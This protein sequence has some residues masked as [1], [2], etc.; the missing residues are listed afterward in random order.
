MRGYVARLGRSDGSV[1]DV[2]SASQLG[3]VRV[4]VFTSDPK[5]DLIEGH[6]RVPL[7]WTH[8]QAHSA[9]RQQRD[10]WLASNIKAWVEW[11]EHKGWRL[12]SKPLVQGPFDAP[13]VNALAE[14]PDFAIY[15]VQAYFQPTALMTVGLDDGYELERRARMYGVDV[16]KPKPVSTPIET[17]PDVIYDSGRFDDPMVVA[18]Q[19]RQA[20]GVRREDF[21]M[22]PLD[23]PM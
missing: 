7:A 2:H 9:E 4:P 23:E 16:S 11:R 17:G 3:G 22:G 21:L 8:T 14:A 1:R 20:M 10:A 19:R 18:E 15:T 12:N 5:G 6:I 13:T